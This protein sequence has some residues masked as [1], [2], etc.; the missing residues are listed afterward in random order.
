MVVCNAD[1]CLNSWKTC[2]VLSGVY[3]NLRTYM[4]C[5]IGCFL[6]NGHKKANKRFSKGFFV[7]FSI[8]SQAV[9]TRLAAKGSLHNVDLI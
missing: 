7:I 2:S 8:K 4:F 6:S 9:V 1:Q 3:I 5:T